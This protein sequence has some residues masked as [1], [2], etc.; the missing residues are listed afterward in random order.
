MGGGQIHNQQHQQVMDQIPFY[1]DDQPSS[2]TMLQLATS[3]SSSPQFYPYRLLPTHP[4]L[5]DYGNTNSP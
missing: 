2:S 3:S 5:Q 1:A 4:N